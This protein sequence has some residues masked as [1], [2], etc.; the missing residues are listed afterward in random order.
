MAYTGP[1]RD[2]AAVFSVEVVQSEAETS[3][4]ASFKTT[5][6]VHSATPPERD[7]SVGRYGVPATLPIAAIRASWPSPTVGGER[8]R[9]RQTRAPGV[10]V[11]PHRY[12]STGAN[13]PDRRLRRMGYSERDGGIG[14]RPRMPW[15]GLAKPRTGFESRRRYHND[16]RV[17]VNGSGNRLYGFPGLPGPSRRSRRYRWLKKQADQRISEPLLVAGWTPASLKDELDVP[18]GA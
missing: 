13:A 5:A 8:D 12:G 11:C 14:G 16:P 9:G 1:Q 15:P 6:F 10:L 18:I 3:I 2:S 17:S 4:A 7:S